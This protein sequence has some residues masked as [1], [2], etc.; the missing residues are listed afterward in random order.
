MVLG[1][2]DTLKP[3]V[4]VHRPIPAIYN[5]E[6][7]PMAS[8]D[9]PKQAEDQMFR[10]LGRLDDHCKDILSTT[11]ERQKLLLT[12]IHYQGM[13]AFYQR[14][15]EMLLEEIEA[16]RRQLREAGHEPR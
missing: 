7:M 3:E 10:A 6:S 8:L 12:I 1:P 11:D 2:G 16:L 15:R 4:P 9:M 5:H 13:D 14:E